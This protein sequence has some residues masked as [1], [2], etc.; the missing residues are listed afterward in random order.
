M[1]YSVIFH[2]EVKDGEYI[3]FSIKLLIFIVLGIYFN[4]TVSV[5]ET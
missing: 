5:Y 4:V 1:R 2:E 3:R